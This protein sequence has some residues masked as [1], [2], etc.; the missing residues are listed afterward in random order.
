MTDGLTHGITHPIISIDL[1]YTHCAISTSGKR[2]VVRYIL[3]LWTVAHSDWDYFKTPLNHNVR[4]SS[5]PGRAVDTSEL[6]LPTHTHRHHQL[7]NPSPVS[8]VSV[9]LSWERRS[10]CQWFAALVLS[11]VAGVEAGDG[12]IVG[13]P[14]ANQR[15]QLQ[16][17]QVSALL[18]HAGLQLGQGWSLARPL[19]SQLSSAR[20]F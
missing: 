1:K 18:A 16:C 19:L 15:P 12:A 2:A 17:W 20:V 4:N 5:S 14:P 6:W 10:D 13:Q 3:L 9:K 8:V 11:D 7:R